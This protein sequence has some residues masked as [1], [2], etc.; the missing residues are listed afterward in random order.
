MF[1]SLITLGLLAAAR[2]PAVDAPIDDFFNS[3]TAEWVRGNPNL[4]TSARYFTGAQQDALEQQL[5]PVGDAYQRSRI[6]LARK[7]LA[8]LRKFDRS[9]MTPVQR[10]SAELL[11]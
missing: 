3:F 2:L 7:G 4:A 5:T 6:Q 8:D 9:K 10:Q 1:R 11:E